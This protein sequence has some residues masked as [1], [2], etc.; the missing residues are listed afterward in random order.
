[1]D[2][3]DGAGAAAASSGARMRLNALNRGKNWAKVELMYLKASERDKA[4]KKAAILSAL[5]PHG[6]IFETAQALTDSDPNITATALMNALVNEHGEEEVSGPRWPNWPTFAE[7][8]S[9]R[10]HAEAMVEEARV[11]QANDE[12]LRAAFVSSLHGRERTLARQ[13]INANKNVSAYELMA[14]IVV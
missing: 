1:M 9:I 4:E 14:Y 8:D 5:T 12:T 2:A 7:K 11:S 6:E 3:P 13:R 10:S